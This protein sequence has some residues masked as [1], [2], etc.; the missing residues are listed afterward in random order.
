MAARGYARWIV[1]ILLLTGISCGKTTRVDK[2]PVEEVASVAGGAQ[3]SGSQEPTVAEMEQLIARL[4]PL[5]TR[6]GPPEPGD[7]LDVHDEPGQTFEQYRK[8]SPVTARGARKVIYIQPI[9]TFTKGQR[10]V[11]EQTAEFMA[12][13]FGLEVKTLAD[14]PVGGGWPEHAR[15][16]HPSWGDEQLLTTHILD[17]VLKPRLPAD[18]ATIL[19]FTAM[20]LWPGR[21]W[22]FVFG[23]ASLRDRVGV[24]SIYRKGDADGGVAE[25]RKCLLRT[26]KTATHETGHMFSA[27]HCTAYECN[28][29][30][31]NSLDES[32]RRPLALCPQCLAKLVWATGVDPVDRFDKLAAFCNK[33]GLDHEA[34]FYERSRAALAA[35]PGS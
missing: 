2:V 3:T 31:S 13:F 32:D 34:A 20:D 16:V 21:G 9:G 4:T 26:V 25:R 19:G 14:I 11:V 27:L 33:V 23:Q 10:R 6:L 28:M 12:L 1:L 17:D 29:C 15:R 5:H 18:G 30:G 7:W 24:W 22:N 8:S 35:G